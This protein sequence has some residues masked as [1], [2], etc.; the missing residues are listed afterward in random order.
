MHELPGGTVTLLFSDI[1]G[2]TRL[3]RALG[4]G[5]GDVLRDHRAIVRSSLERTNGIEV[6]STGD[7]FFA[8]FGSAGDAAAAAAEIQREHRAR[9]WPAGEELR[10][11]IA[12][13]TGEPRVGDE[14]YLGLDVVR[15]AR[16]CGVA[17]GGQVLA[18]AATTE[19]VRGRLPEGVELR[20]VGRVELKDIDEPESIAEIVIDGVR[21]EHGGASGAPALPGGDWERKFEHAIEELTRAR[22]E[23]LSERLLHGLAVLDSSGKLSRLEEGGFHYEPSREAKR[24]GLLVVG[25]VALALVGAIAILV[26]LV[27][28]VV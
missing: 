21:G 15:A 24:V 4:D 9:T 6:D 16:V 26:W 8:V 27:G 22:A 14:G 23:E 3:V 12:L 1:E 7:G 11:R 13:H 2:S 20:D 5:W 17:H 19:L 10:V 18:T 25:G 28:L